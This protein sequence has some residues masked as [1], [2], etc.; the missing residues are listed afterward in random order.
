MKKLSIA[1]IL[2]LIS[3]PF[4]TQAQYCNNF[5]RKYCKLSPT[6]TDIFNYNGQS[7]SALF[8]KGQTSQLR[9]IAY[10][11]H[12]YRISICTEASLGAEVAFK[13]RDGKTGDLLFDNSEDD[14]TQQ[15]EF[16][17]ENTRSLTLE[18]IV[19]SG[20]TKEEKFKSSDMACLGVL[21]EHKATEKTGF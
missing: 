16:S 7:K 6:S 8:E 4:F 15:F 5:H 3:I 18:V 14:L 10:K 21:I 2:A 12:D 13:I 20:Q 1:L 19:P 17:C 11:D 9:F